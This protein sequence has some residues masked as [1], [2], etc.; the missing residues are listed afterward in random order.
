MDLSAEIKD[1]NKT[2][3][4]DN[5][6]HDTKL[7]QLYL[8]CD[9]FSDEDVSCQE[10]VVRDEQKSSVCD[11]FGSKLAEDRLQKDKRK[12]YKE[13]KVSWDQVSNTIAQADFMSV[14][15]DKKEVKRP[16]KEEGEELAFK[17]EENK[18]KKS[19]DHR[20][21]YK[22]QHCCKSFSRKG[23]LKVHSLTCTLQNE[24]HNKLSTECNKTSSSNIRPHSVTRTGEKTHTCEK[25]R[26]HFSKN[27][28]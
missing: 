20:N 11:K 16:C 17:G 2:Q 24:L 1:R 21:I 14:S 26:K 15:I 23:S 27:G 12:I 13:E 7:F 22:C 9:G 10:M 18:V 5:D 4:D 8:C 6:D 28:L 19:R 3:D 25:C